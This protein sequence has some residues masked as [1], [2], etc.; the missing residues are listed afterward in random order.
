MTAE[1]HR[2]LT[3]AQFRGLSLA[4]QGE[5]VILHGPKEA[6]DELRELLRACK[7]ELREHLRAQ[8]RAEVLAAYRA[9]YQ[10]IEA[11]YPTGTDS[12]RAELEATF[13]D[14]VAIADRAGQAAERAAVS[15]QDGATASPDAF[16]R[17]L[18]AWERAVLD[19]FAAL[20]SARSSRLCVDC[21]REAVVTV[22]TGL[23]QRVCSR[24]LRK[25]AAP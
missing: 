12:A 20:D 11:A 8:R 13:P 10:R 9:A 18:A 22:L 7:D 24:C 3:L 6:R 23:G 25:E 17:A 14:L 5:A 1:A 21:G 4:L 19:G 2:A 16:T 15:Y